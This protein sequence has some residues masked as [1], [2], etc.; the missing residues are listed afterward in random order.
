MLLFWKISVVDC[1]GLLVA[2]SDSDAF[3]CNQYFSRRSSAASSHLHTACS[4]VKEG[5]SVLVLVYE[6]PYSI[7]GKT[8]AEICI[9]KAECLHFILQVISHILYRLDESALYKVLKSWKSVIYYFYLWY[10]KFILILK[11]VYFQFRK[12]LETS[13]VMFLFLWAGTPDRGS[14]PRMLRH[15]LWLQM[16]SPQ[17]DG[18]RV[19]WWYVSFIF[20]QWGKMENRQPSL[21]QW[22]SC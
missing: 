14:T 20:V 9:M 4:Q 21:C 7:L 19:I 15:R 8:T 1:C 12:C 10:L 3:R 17:Q 11:L 13:A 16:T 5:V 2:L 6:L 18:A 22:F